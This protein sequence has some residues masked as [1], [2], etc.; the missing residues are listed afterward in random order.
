MRIRISHGLLPRLCGGSMIK[1]KWIRKLQ[2]QGWGTRRSWR[3]T[4]A[5]ATDVIKRQA[6]DEVFREKKK[7]WCDY[8]DAS[9]YVRVLP[10]SWV[11][12]SPTIS[13]SL[14]DQVMM[15]LLDQ[16]MIWFSKA[17]AYEIRLYKIDRA[18]LGLRWHQVT[19]DC[20]LKHCH[21][22]RDGCSDSYWVIVNLNYVWKASCKVIILS[23][24]PSSYLGLRC[25]NFCSGGLKLGH[26]RGWSSQAWPACSVS[27]LFR[28]N[29]ICV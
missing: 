14:L 22:F 6:N 8:F 28:V 23:E 19:T 21:G 5:E 7:I 26:L 3:I 13:F 20:N 1:N 12:R 29:L 15:T 11:K 18:C 9:P 17:P 24:S 2:F 16:V 10:L 25:D 27:D 4:S